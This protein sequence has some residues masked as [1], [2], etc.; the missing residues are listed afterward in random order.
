VSVQGPEPATTITV[1]PAKFSL[2]IDA[3]QQLTAVVRDANGNALTEKSITWSSGTPSVA[4]VTATGMV[5]GVSPGNVIITATVEGI[6][7]SATITVA[8]IP[9]ST[10][11]TTLIADP[12]E[13]GTVSGT[14]NL[15]QTPNTVIVSKIGERVDFKAVANDGYTFTGWKLLGSLWS[16][17]YSPAIL[18]DKNN[19]YVAQFEKIPAQDTC[20]CYFIAPIVAG[21]PFD[22]TYRTCTAGSTRKTETFTNFTNI[23]SADIPA[24]GNNAQVP[25]NQGS[26]CVNTQTCSPPPPTGQG[27]KPFQR[28]APR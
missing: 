26:R 6:T 20:T 10:Y 11:T 2:N 14:S 28:S 23:C 3:T 9:T 5:K 21:Q 27:S 16:T 1:D 17:N 12:P 18:S 25:Q 13:G 19:T 24:A 4:T 22:V 8:A 7:G 15:T